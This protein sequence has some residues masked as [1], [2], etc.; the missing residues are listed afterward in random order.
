MLHSDATEVYETEEDSYSVLVV[1]R[2]AR[3]WLTWATVNAVGATSAMNKEEVR[4]SFSLALPGLVCRLRRVVLTNGYLY[5]FDTVK[6]ALH[7]K[8]C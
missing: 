2:M 8:K 3:T 5:H 7:T 1:K 4:N 6:D